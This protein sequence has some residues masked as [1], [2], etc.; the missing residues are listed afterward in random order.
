MS[1][2][3]LELKHVQ[4]DHDRLMERHSALLT[5]MAAK[6]RQSREKQ[7][8]LLKLANSAEKARQDAIASLQEQTEALR[9]K[10]KVRNLLL[11]ANAAPCQQFDTHIFPDSLNWRSRIP[12]TRRMCP[13]SIS[14][15]MTWT[16]KSFDSRTSG[17]KSLVMTLI[18]KTAWHI[19]LAF[20]LEACKKQRNPVGKLTTR[21]MMWSI[22]WKGR[23]PRAPSQWQ[24]VPP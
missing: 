21:L 5:D 23:L 11:P 15:L 9:Q 13:S 24:N 20:I 6:E 8:Q 19:F 14:R 16:T 17:G 22:T 3:D 4:E 18:R 2:T 7:E 10:Y 12:S 1:S